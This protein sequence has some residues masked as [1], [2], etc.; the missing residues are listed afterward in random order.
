M[1]ESS[2]YQSHLCPD[3]FPFTVTISTLKYWPTPSNSMDTIC[4]GSC[5]HTPTGISSL[6]SAIK[7]ALRRGRRTTYDR[8]MT[9]KEN[10]MLI[11]SKSSSQ[12]LSTGTLCH[13]RNT[14]TRGHFVEV[15]P[16]LAQLPPYIILLPVFM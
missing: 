10:T 15:I 9:P 8:G 5:A 2:S 3:R 12:T 13:E 1:P 16:R 6:F 4:H 14:N 11:Y 7:V